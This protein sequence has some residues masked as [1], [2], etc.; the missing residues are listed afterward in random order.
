M[1]PWREHSAR[2]RLQRIAIE[3]GFDRLAAISET[4]SLEEIINVIQ[5][6]ERPDQVVRGFFL[7]TVRLRKK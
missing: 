1:I 5:T 3:L 2:E 4:G 6:E 7:V